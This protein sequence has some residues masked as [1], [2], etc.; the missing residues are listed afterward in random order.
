MLSREEIQAVYA[1]GPE[2][3]IEL[4]Q[5]LSSALEQQGE[6][7]SQLAARVKELEERLAK[8]SH[9]SHKPPSSDPPFKS[10][11]L[12]EKSGKSPGGQR[13]HQGY[14]LKL[15]DEPDRIITH[16]P[17]Q[18]VRCGHSLADVKPYEY[19]R[20]QVVELPEVSL[21]TIE[22]RVERKR[23][24]HCELTTE[25]EY[26]DE[27][28]AVTGYG[29]RV[30]G[31]SVYLHE[32]QLLPFERTVECIEDVFGV[33]VSAGTLQL[34]DESCYEALEQ[35]EEMIRQG[36]SQSEVAHFD[37]TGLD[38]EGRKLWIHVGSTDKLTHYGLHTKRGSEAMDEI[39]ILPRFEGV[40]SHD[41]LYAYHE[42]DCLHALCNVHHLRELSFI[43]EQHH[44]EWAGQM[45]WLLLEVKQ[46]VELA[47]K[48][49]V[50]RLDEGLR[51]RYEVRYE[52][53][54]EEG[55]AANPEPE[56]TGKPGRHKRTPGRNLAERL[57]K[58]QQE[59]LRFMY[60]FDVPFDNNQAERDLRMIK[61]QQKVSG[62]FR[63]IGGAQRFCRIRSYI[64]TARKQGQG[65][66]AAL[67]AALRGQ[68]FTPCSI[69][70]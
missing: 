6:Q 54:L 33:K 66:L 14:T 12:R 53:L 35:T 56:A 3:V 48:S 39:G 11:S 7:I 47:V 9:N 41:G 24:P 40:A 30:K 15:R 68:P 59:V 64:S 25:A 28:T 70:E 13:G 67:E 16:S 69:A 57:G 60:D 36:V 65:V 21:E 61:V 43:E 51:Q 38:V 42:Y 37:E 22:H 62:C 34:N 8:D 26:P 50:L 31:L 32:Y 44:Q 55:L 52:Q 46:A 19:K 27:A 29:P 20:H 49:G 18:C 2:A 10:K 45:K 4:V 63:T 17:E 1:Q 58:Y 5:G 23:C